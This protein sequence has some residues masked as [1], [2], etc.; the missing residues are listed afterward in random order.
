MEKIFV[1][2]KE[3][4]S[5]YNSNKARYYSLTNGHDAYFEGINGTALSEAKQYAAKHGFTTMKL[6]GNRWNQKD[7]IYNIKTKTQ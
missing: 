6:I 1:I 5:E 2:G 4:F 3:P 7:K